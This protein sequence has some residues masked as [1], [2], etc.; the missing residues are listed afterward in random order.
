MIAAAIIAAADVV[1]NYARSNS[2]YTGELRLKPRS[3]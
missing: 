1:V 3:S 2:F